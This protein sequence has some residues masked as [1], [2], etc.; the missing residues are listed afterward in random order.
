M[1][2][3]FENL[4]EKYIQ[5]LLKMAILGTSPTN[6]SVLNINKLHVASETIDTF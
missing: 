5:K 6:N 2:N 3:T 4:K 1:Q